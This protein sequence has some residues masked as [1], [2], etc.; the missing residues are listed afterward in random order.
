[1]RD[2]VTVKSAGNQEPIDDETVAYIL[3]AQGL[4]E[5]LQQVA[6]QLAGLLVLAASGGRSATP[7]H[8]MLGTAKQLHQCAAASIQSL[9]PTARASA[10]CGHVTQASAALG[11]AL[12]SAQ[13]YLGRP[14]HGAGVDQ[15]LD[16]LKAACDQLLL[17]ASVLPGFQVISFEQACCGPQ[18]PA[19][20]MA[21]DSRSK[22]GARIGK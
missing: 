15:V 22:S 13:T 8:P 19:D 20:D 7:D 1:V 5:D 14:E 3:S 18:I 17:A 11:R 12:S 9:R 21:S 16:P 10:H 6:A 2:E 4:F